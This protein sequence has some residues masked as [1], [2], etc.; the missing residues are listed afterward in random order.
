M[1]EQVK[2]CETCGY[3]AS[4]NELEEQGEGL[5]PA[6]GKPYQ[7]KEKEVMPLVD[8]GITEW[9]YADGARDQRDADQKWHE[10]KLEAAKREWVKQEVDK[11]EAAIQD[12]RGSFHRIARVENIIAELRKEAGE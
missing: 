11:L 5:C 6:C 2:S 12:N 8:A 7:P 3:T 9:D 4:Q 10:D 1:S